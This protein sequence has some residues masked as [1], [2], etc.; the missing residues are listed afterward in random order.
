MLPRSC[1]GDGLC[2]LLWVDRF[3]NLS[4]TCQ[5]VFRRQP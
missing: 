2:Q 3:V 1:P 5:G 4:T